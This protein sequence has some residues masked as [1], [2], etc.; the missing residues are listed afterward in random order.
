MYIYPV[1]SFFHVYLITYNVV[2]SEGYTQHLMYGVSMWQCDPV[3]FL[4]M[5]L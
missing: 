4:Y 1:N 3:E 5:S 2:L